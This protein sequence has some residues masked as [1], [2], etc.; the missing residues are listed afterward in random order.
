[1]QA[2]REREKDGPTDTAAAPSYENYLAAQK[3]VTY[4]EF[5]PEFPPEFAPQITPN[6]EESPYQP[7]TPQSTSPQ[8]EQPKPNEQSSNEENESSPSSA[9]NFTSK[10]I[11][12]KSNKNKV[13]SNDKEVEDKLDGADKYKEI[14]TEIQT[15]EM[16]SKPDK[17]IEAEAI[18]TPNKKTKSGSDPS[19]LPSVNAT[20]NAIPVSN[21]VPTSMKKE[22]LGFLPNGCHNIFPFIKSKSNSSKKESKEKK[23]KNVID[24][25]SNSKI[26]ISNK[27]QS[28]N[29]SGFKE[30][31][32]VEKM[33]KLK[34]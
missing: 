34:L 22:K 16:V 1:M 10:S 6:Q 21:P 4:I 9:I 19:S 14:L 30:D 23:I 29:E 7:P 18:S 28:E 32:N 20:S 17:P 3:Q 5:G 31:A 27:M 11:N 8:S 33:Q 12:G 25:V 13:N 26:E 24:F 2:Q 15:N